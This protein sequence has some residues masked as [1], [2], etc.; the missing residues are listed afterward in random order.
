[1]VALLQNGADP[2]QTDQ[3]GFRAVDYL[4]SPLGPFFVMVHPDPTHA[5]MNARITKRLLLAASLH[6]RLQL[7]LACGSG[8]HD[9]VLSKLPLLV[10]DKVVELIL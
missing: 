3:S 9:T 2:V 10:L 1:M 5:E 6:V 4:Y 7:T 8:E